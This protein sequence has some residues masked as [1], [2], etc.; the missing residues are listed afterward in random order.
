MRREY[1]DFQTPHNLSKTVCDSLLSSGISPE[2]L[3]EPTFGKGS[4]ILSALKTFP[5][6]RQVYGLE[7]Y[8]PY[9]WYTKFSILELFIDNPNFNHPSIYLYHEDVFKSDFRK[10]VETNNKWESLPDTC[11]TACRRRWQAGIPLGQEILV[12]GNPPWV[13]NSELSTLN[14]TNIPTKGNFKSHNGLD[15][16]TG[17]GN[18]DIGEYI[19]LMMLNAFSDRSGCLAMLAKNSVIKNVLQDLPNTTYPIS[20]IVAL[21][22]DA[23]LHFNASVD[24]SLFRC[25]FGSRKAG[26]DRL[27]CKVASLV[28]PQSVESEF[29]WVG[30]KFVSNIAAYQETQSYDGSSPFV[31]RQGVKHD[32]SKILELD[33]VEGKYR[34]GFNDFVDIEDDL[35]FPLVK[36]SDVQN[37]PLSIPRKFVIITQ[38]K[39]G[40][41]TTYIAERF[42]RL[43]RYLSTNLKFLSERKSSIYSGKSEYA[44][45]GIGEYSFKPYK[46]AISGLYKKPDFSLVQP[47]T[48]KPTMLDDTCYFLGFDDQTQAAFGL[49]ILNSE[50]VQKLLRSLTFLEAKRPY[51]KDILMRIDI[52]KV[53]EHLGF[54]SVRRGK[55]G[56]KLPESILQLLTRE[57][58]VEFLASCES[59]SQSKPQYS[60]F[61]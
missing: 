13:T 4:F 27:T 51:T 8:E 22:F 48:G 45:F 38:K 47:Y 5:T 35:V 44:I 31:W 57:K 42:P 58:W 6:L 11:P 12:L 14:S 33:L 54:D 18:F 28:S 59:V 50:P 39:V 36:S 52:L 20:N 29:G 23:K 43:N 37:S 19:I 9:C 32:C 24:A 30:N 3:I 61:G 26:Q 7:I 49:I 15:A 41:D 10:L 2:V 34:N 21:K 1:G 60:L 25:N 55:L 40:D 17:K 16:I 56:D 53:A 46:V